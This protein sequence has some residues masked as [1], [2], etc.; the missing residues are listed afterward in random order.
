MKVMLILMLLSRKHHLYFPVPLHSP[1]PL[2]ISWILL[3][4]HHLLQPS[5][6]QHPLPSR[7]KLNSHHGHHHV[8]VTPVTHRPCASVSDL[9][10]TPMTHQPCTSA[11]DPMWVRTRHNGYVRVDRVG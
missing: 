6:P 7:P 10:L 5:R 11:S 8:P 2:S 1:C 3:G 4:C 9:M